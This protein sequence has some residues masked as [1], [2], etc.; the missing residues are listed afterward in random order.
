MIYKN[1]KKEKLTT[2]FI[3]SLQSILEIIDLETIDGILNSRDSD[4][5]SNLWTKARDEI[6]IE[7]I[8]LDAERE[9][10]FKLVFSKTKSDDLSA[11]ITEDFELITSYIGLKENNW[12]TSL[13]HSYFNRK[14]PEGEIEYSNKTLIEL[15]NEQV[16]NECTIMAIF[17]TG[18]GA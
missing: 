1:L 18:F 2:K 14:I 13:C 5:F 15:I 8:N 7:E 6:E 9:K 4:L 11:Y 3:N 17:N 12:V 10:I 16:K